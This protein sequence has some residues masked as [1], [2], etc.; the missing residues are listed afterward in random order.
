MDFQREYGHTRVPHVYPK[1]PKLGRWCHHIKLSFKKLEQGEKPMI[2]VKQ[3]HI[4]KLNAI[5]FQWKIRFLVATNKDDNEDDF[6]TQLVK[7]KAFKDTNGHCDVKRHCN[8]DN[9]NLAYW[10]ASLRSSYRQLRQGE[11]PIMKL[12]EKQISLLNDLGFDW[13]DTFE[14]QSVKTKSITVPWS[15][16]Y[17]Q[18][19]EYKARYGNCR[20]PSKY[21][22]DKALG[23][24]K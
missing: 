17:K 18:L 8:T 3:E 9:D 21:A 15:E 12:N 4:E 23:N 13:S 20:V 2:K 11:R 16:R 7:L 10:V 1:N 22:D 5:N 6:D 14:S 24:C 19:C